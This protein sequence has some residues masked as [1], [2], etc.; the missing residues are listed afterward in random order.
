MGLTDSIAG[1]LVCAVAV[2]GLTLVASY[3]SGVVHTGMTVDDFIEQYLELYRWEDNAYP[4]SQHAINKDHVLYNHS[5]KHILIILSVMAFVIV[6]VGTM[7]LGSISMKTKSVKRRFQFWWSAVTSIF[8]SVI[9]VYYSLLHTDFLIDDFWVAEFWKEYAIA[10]SRYLYPS[11]FI[12]TL[13]YASSFIVLPLIVISAITVFI[14]HSSSSYLVVLSSSLYIYSTIIYLVEN[15]ITGYKGLNN[16]EPIYFYIYYIGSNLLPILGSSISIVLEVLDQKYDINR[17]LGLITDED[18]V[19]P[20]VVPGEVDF[21][22]FKSSYFSPPVTKKKEEEST[23]EK[24]KKKNNTK[25][26]EVKIDDKEIRKSKTD[27]DSNLRQR[28]KK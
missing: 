4:F 1:Q 26:K 18:Y 10:D 22:G 16:L 15:H 27:N 12:L 21:T 9:G 19:E 14:N 6:L 17:S 3:I 5:P 2:L 13:S 7:I 11:S 24:P 20:E 23:T 28:K 8:L 25:S